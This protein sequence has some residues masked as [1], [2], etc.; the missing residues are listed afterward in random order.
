VGV[1]RQR[2]C[3]LAPRQAIERGDDGVRA[4]VELID[5]IARYSRRAVST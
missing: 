2:R 5:G 3:A 1:T 4:G